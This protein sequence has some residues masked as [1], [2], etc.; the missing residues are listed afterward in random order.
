MKQSTILLSVCG[1]FAVLGL[2][3]GGWLFVK[4]RRAPEGQGSERSPGSNAAQGTQVK[5]GGRT[6]GVLARMS[7]TNGG[8]GKIAGALTNGAPQTAEQSMAVKM[9]DFLDTGDEAAA[10]QVALKLKTAEEAA[11]RADVVEVLGWIGIKALPILSQLMVD[12]DPDVA[13]AAIAQWKRTL[14]EIADDSMKADMLIAGMSVIKDQDELESCVMEFNHL[15]NDLA[16]R[17]LVKLIQ[18]DNP[19]ASEIGRA[20]YEFVTSEAYHSPEAAEKW[21]KENQDQ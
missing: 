5:N 9:H 6:N 19:R 14:S 10:L 20:H 2:G 4:E 12:P 15:P 7:G 21:I 8:G 13:R 17:G 11:V 1:V 16:V 3:F 18:S